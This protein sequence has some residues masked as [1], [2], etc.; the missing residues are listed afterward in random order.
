[1]PNILTTT[2][3]I[4]QNHPKKS[5]LAFKPMPGQ[6]DKEEKSVKSKATKLKLAQISQIPATIEDNKENMLGQR[7]VYCLM[8]TLGVNIFAIIWSMFALYSPEQPNVWNEN[9]QT[10]TSKWIISVSCL[11]MASLV[12]LIRWLDLKQ[13]PYDDRKRYRMSLT[14]E[15]LLLFVHVP[16]VSFGAFDRK[17]D[18]YNIYGILKIYLLSELIKIKHPLWLRRNEVASSQAKVSG[19]PVFVGNFFCLSCLGLEYDFTSFFFF[20]TFGLIALCTVT[21]YFVERWVSVYNFS[22]S[23]DDIFSVMFHV[24][25][26][27]HLPGSCEGYETSETYTG[28]K[29]FIGCFFFMNRALVGWT[30]GFRLAENSD[31]FEDLLNDVNDYINHR[32]YMAQVIQKWWRK[33]LEARL[34]RRRSML[35]WNKALICLQGKRIKSSITK[36][37]L[38]GEMDK[39]WKGVLA[40]QETN[41]K[42]LLAHQE[43]KRLMLLFISK[44]LAGKSIT[45][46]LTDRIENSSLARVPDVHVQFQEES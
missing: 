34:Y 35:S 18:L 4:M 23:V 32:H 10:K 30:F 29:L 36:A 25:R 13:L 22:N 41:Q 40:L 6:K 24:P 39:T 2:T 43:L 3:C 21:V 12:S 33:Q 38:A 15:V 45:Q 46:S 42:L 1:M 31:T 14:L 5:S 20:I 17:V 8:T 44:R 37:D 19:S 7:Y 28:I 9:W 26:A 16:P 11:T 27:C